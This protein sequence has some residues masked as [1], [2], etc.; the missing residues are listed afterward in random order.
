MSRVYTSV[1][2][3]LFIAV[4]SAIV[5]VVTTFGSIVLGH[6]SQRIEDAR[7]RQAR[8]DLISIQN[9]LCVYALE[10][11]GRFPR[12]LVEV[13]QWDPEGIPWATLVDPWGHAYQYMPPTSGDPVPRV[14]C[15]GSD[16]RLGG[17][18][19]AADIDDT[20]AS[21]VEGE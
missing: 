13:T 21:L 10:H 9:I 6:A 19:S 15:L 18:G 5:A 8:V 20:V 14:L 12:S 11:G 4:G 17:A 3:G 7:V 1:W 2:K 16:G